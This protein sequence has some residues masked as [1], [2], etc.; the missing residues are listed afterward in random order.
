MKRRANALREA[1]VAAQF[2]QYP[3]IG[4]GFGLGIGTAAEGWLEAAVQFWEKHMASNTIRRPY[5]SM[6]TRK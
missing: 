3:N 5:D 6:K 1:G 2:R 4:H